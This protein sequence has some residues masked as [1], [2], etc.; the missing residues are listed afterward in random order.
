MTLS[1]GHMPIGYR[2]FVAL[3][4]RDARPDFALIVKVETCTTEEEAREFISSWRPINAEEFCAF[5]ACVVP[6]FRL[7]P[8]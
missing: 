6:V 3:G 2:A 4:A 7:N 8:S 5:A 1:E